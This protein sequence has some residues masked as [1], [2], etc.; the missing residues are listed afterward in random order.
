M[1]G[2]AHGVGAP[3]QVTHP[4]EPFYRQGQAGQKPD[5]QQAMALTAASE[6]ANRPF[7][8]DLRIT[9]LPA[10]PPRFS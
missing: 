8:P 7:R 2:G 6:T 5:H 3:M 4:V 1:D 9:H 10:F